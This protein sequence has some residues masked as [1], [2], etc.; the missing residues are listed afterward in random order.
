MLLQPEP[1]S[2]TVGIDNFHLHAAARFLAA[3]YD[4]H[5]SNLIMTIEHRLP[6]QRNHKTIVRNIHPMIERYRSLLRLIMVADITD[7]D[8]VFILAIPENIIIV[9]MVRA[10][11]NGISNVVRHSMRIIITSFQYHISGFL[12]REFGFIPLFF[13][14]T[15]VGRIRDLSVW[16]ALMLRHVKPERQRLPVGQ[17]LIP[18]KRSQFHRIQRIAAPDGFSQ[19]ILQENTFG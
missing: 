1:V 9:G 16:Q 15:D 13:V 2:R 18:F 6:L 7:R 14:F 10:Q 4:I 3:Q 5:R 8:I 17:H 19:L 12:L 11:I